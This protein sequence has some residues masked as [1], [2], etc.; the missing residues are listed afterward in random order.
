MAPSTPGIARTR[1]SASAA[2]RLEI[3]RPLGGHRD[4]EHDLAAGDEDVRDEPAR[5]DVAVAVGCG[6]RPEAFEDLVLGDVGHGMIRG[7]EW[8]GTVVRP[9]ARSIPDGPYSAALP[10]IHANRDRLGY[11]GAMIASRP[12]LGVILAGGRST[13]LGGGDKPLLALGGRPLLA[14]VID[15]LR[16]QVRAL[17]LNAN[18]D[19]ARFA[20]FDLPVVPDPVGGFAGPLAGILAGLIWARGQADPPEGIV[21]AAADTPFFPADL[22]ARLTAAAGEDGLAIARSNGRL[23]PVFG[24]FPIACTDDLDAVPETPG[25]AQGHR[26]ARSTGLYGGRLPGRGRAR[27]PVLQHQHASRSRR[28]RGIDLAGGLIS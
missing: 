11:G 15:R 19:P 9:S 16:P 18:G 14:R 3:A 12:V 8:R 10:V 21:T 26:L 23:H 13:R 6:N 17:A 5:D 27:R 1:R 20:A 25:I 2:H 24:Y 4:R 7:L 22:A 28:R